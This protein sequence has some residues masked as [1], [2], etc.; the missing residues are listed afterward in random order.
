MNVFS[1]LRLPLIFVILFNVAMICTSCSQD[2]ALIQ[3]RPI[4]PNPFPYSLERP[5]ERFILPAILHEVS[6]LS[7][8]Q[9]NQLAMLQDELGR[10]FIF[11]YAKGEITA[12]KKFGKN[13]DYEGIEKA[14]ENLY[15]LQ[16]D[17]D[18]FI[19]SSSA[20]S[21]LSSV[22]FENALAK[23][24]DTEGLAYDR[25]NHHLWISCKADPYLGEKRYKGCRAVYAFDLD[26]DSL[27]PTPV[28]LLHRDSIKA[29]LQRQL[30]PGQ[31]W[32][33]EKVKFHPSAIA[34][35]PLTGEVYWLSAADKL[36]LALNRKGEMQKAFH[37]DP[38]LFKHPE[39]MCFCLMAPCLSPMKEMRANQTC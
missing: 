22:K 14:G 26:Q 34:F 13:G 17:G 23:T 24:N 28:L 27:L 2:S 9:E 10:L 18:V 8:V 32:P 36:L 21:T 11:D 39:G 20:D 5:D 33:E 29:W 1:L 30:P 3:S 31:Q 25:E 12:E 16:S 4:L 7:F 37:L 35:H 15:A 38:K 6:A 19:I